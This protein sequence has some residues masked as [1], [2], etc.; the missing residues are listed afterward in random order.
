MAKHAKISVSDWKHLLLT[1]ET[2]KGSRLKPVGANAS[3]I[4]TH[5]PLWAGVIAYDE[6][7]ESIVT[8]RVPPWRPQDMPP[9]AK[10]GDWTDANTTRLQSWFSDAYALDLGTG[11][12]LEAVQV[13]AERHT[14]HPVREWIQ[15]LRWDGKRRVSGWLTDIMGC[16]DTPYTRECGLSFFVSAVARVM[17]PGCKVDTTVI[18]EGEQG[19]FKS[20]VIRALAGDEWFLEMSISD[21]ASKDAMQ[22]LRRKWIGE[23]PEIDGLSRSEWSHVKSYFS[24]VVDTYR[25]SYGKGSRDFPRQTVFVGSTNRTDYLGDDTGAR[26]FYPVRCRAGNV[27]L[28][29][30]LREQLWAEALTMYESGVKWHVTD[31]AL[32]EE[33]KAEQAARYRPHPWE[34][35]IASWLERPVDIPLGKKRSEIGVTTADVLEGALRIE[36]GRR[37]LADANNVASCLRRLGWRQGPQTRRGGARVRLFFPVDAEVAEVPHEPASVV[38]ELPQR[39]FDL[40]DDSDLAALNDE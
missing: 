39:E 10:P 13:V 25:P 14:F 23:M 29:L 38:H 11:T 32:L 22:I 21:V 5:D 33:F 17:V 7:A 40:P 9:N 26:R 35:T 2:K 37:T 20:S 18:L 28:A 30:E 34:E 12:V 31:P 36:I 19:T 1:E 27:A 16:E 24:R 4:L 6:F 8:R 15:S 3:T